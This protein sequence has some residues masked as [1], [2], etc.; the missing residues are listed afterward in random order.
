MA[1][2]GM[3]VVAE[4]T[5]ADRSDAA[6]GGLAA[7][8]SRRARSA[9][10]AGAD[11]ARAPRSR[12]APRRLRHRGPGPATGRAPPTRRPRWRARSARRSPSR[13]SRPTSATRPT[14]E[15]SRSASNPPTTSPG[16]RRAMVSR[17]SGAAPRR[18]HP[19]VPRAA[20]GA[21]GQGAPAGR[22]ARSAVRAAR[23]GR[24]RRNLRRGAAGHGHAPCAGLHRRGRTD[25]GRA[26]DGRRCSGACAASQRWI[27]RRW[28][29]RSPAS[30]CS[31]R[32]ARSW[33][34]WSSIRWSRRRRASSRW[35]RGQ[36]S[37]IGD[38]PRRRHDRRTGTRGA[39][40]T[41]P[42]RLHRQ[43]GG[44]VGPPGMRTRVH[45]LMT[46]TMAAATW[47]SAPR[48]ASGEP[49]LPVTA[50]ASSPS[51]RTAV[52]AVRSQ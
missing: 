7:G 36:P 38:R 33:P 6:A 11:S 2:A 3:A 45:M 42:A 34:R 1:V 30:P 12:A 9:A 14:S 8:C 31:P 4:R 48:A 52:D 15:A 50:A 28:R 16:P 29:R 19:G 46:K 18:G 5:R 32:T 26:P 24:L 25:A 51:A 40:A 43:D 20:D 21:A 37:R 49:R 41:E 13:S 23:D 10:G 27:A 47:P 17:R 44:V 35:T 39:C 22:R